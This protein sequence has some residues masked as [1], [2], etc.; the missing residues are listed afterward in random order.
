MGES[1]FSAMTRDEQIR[2][3]MELWDRIADHDDLPDPLPEQ[4]EEVRARREAHRADPS[5][6]VPL[7]EARRRLRARDE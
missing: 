5:A 7:D 4:L 1:A 3:V 2:H 6:A